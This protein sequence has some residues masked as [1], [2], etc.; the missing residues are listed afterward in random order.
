MGTLCVYEMDFGYL[1]IVYDVLLLQRIAVYNYFMWFLAH[2]VPKLTLWE[3]DFFYFFLLKMV[4][5]AIIILDGFRDDQWRKLV[6]LCMI[7]FSSTNDGCA[8]GRKKPIQQFTIFKKIVFITKDP[9]IRI[10][11]V[12][13]KK[14]NEMAFIKKNTKS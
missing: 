7:F 11:P 10:I 13:T 8:T 9:F 1:T 5:I 4:I 14:I 2:T 3:I 12:D 6:V